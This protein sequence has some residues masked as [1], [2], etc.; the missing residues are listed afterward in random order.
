MVKVQKG[1]KGQMYLENI[2]LIMG[3][4][5]G[6]GPVRV[7]R[8]TRKGQSCRVAGLTSESNLP[9]LIFQV[10]KIYLSIE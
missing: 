9:K 4:G 7:Q 8:S 1:L 2:S 6:L 3:D 10:A 5:L